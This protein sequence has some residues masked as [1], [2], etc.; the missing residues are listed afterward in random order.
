MTAARS[1]NLQPRRLCRSA[2]LLVL[3]SLGLAPPAVAAPAPPPAPA[4]AARREQA[5]AEFNQGNTAYNLDKYEEAIA[6]FEKAYSLSRV[7]EILFNLGQCYRKRWED[8]KKSDLG[9]RA[10]HYYQALVREAPGSRVR[11]D[12]D[13]FIAELEPA[14]AL[15]EARERQGRIDAARGAEALRLAQGFLRDGQTADAATT[16][17]RLLRE[18]D[19]GRELLAE[20]YVVRGRAA[21]RMNDL[22]GAEAQFRRAL[23]LRPSAELADATPPESAPFEAARHTMQ[24]KGGGLRLVQAPIGEV[25]PGKPAALAVTV[26]GDSEQMISTLELGYRRAE[27][28]AGAFVTT[29]VPT[30]A[31]LALP[32]AALT[33]GAR[34]DYYV[35]ALDA[36]GGVLAESGAPT[37]PFRLQVASPA[38]LLVGGGGAGAAAARETPWYKRWWVWTL[39]GAVALGGGGAAV[40]A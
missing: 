1:S 36:H 3:V 18:P 5:K 39:V 14:V 15:A 4:E 9:R 32:A 26:E 38:A 23:E 34:I 35:R 19:N 17:D 37:L 2:S 8:E 30:A 13:Q 10:L 25:P 24:G 16:I 11:A 28:G 7:P 27:G 6:H 31:A 21:A 12:A 33:A 29:R 40:H 20:A 22:L